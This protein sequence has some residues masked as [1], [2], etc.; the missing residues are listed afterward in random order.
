[1]RM[2]INHAKK[3]GVTIHE[4]CPLTN[5]DPDIEASFDRIT[6]EWLGQKK[7]SLLSFTMG[8]VGFDHP[9]DKR[10]FYAENAE[11][12][13]VAFIAFVPFLGK[14]GYMADVTRHGNDAPGG[15]METIIYEAFQ[16]F[17]EEGVHYGSLGVATLAGLDDE[18][19]GLVEQFLRFIYNHLNDCYGFK[20]LYRAKEKYSPTEWLPAY[21]VYLP[22]H[23]TPD[24]FYAVVKIQNPDSIK[25]GIGSIYHGL[26]EH[27]SFPGKSTS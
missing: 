3:A 26:K 1:M 6:H 2:N 10:Y 4:Y 25:E 22:K 7:S 20:D 11:G 21:Y 19:A 27:F 24:M 18:K 14:D 17:R 5:R 12:K 16:T 23:P 9:M 8:T 15:V 13:I